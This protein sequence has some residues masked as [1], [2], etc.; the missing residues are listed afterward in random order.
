MEKKYCWVAECAMTTFTD[1]SKEEFTSIVDCFSDMHSAVLEKVKESTLYD[2][3]TEPCFEDY[4]AYDVKIYPRKIVFTFYDLEY[5]YTIKECRD[6]IIGTYNAHNPTL[7]EKI[8][9]AW[10]NEENDESFKIILLALLKRDMGEYECYFNTHVV[11]N[12]NWAYEHAH[13]I[14]QEICDDTDLETILSFVRYNVGG[15]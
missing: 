6:D 12:E 10:K 13:N 8:N 14:M 9:D 4:V 1:R 15:N 11:L 5:I 2:I 7:V 3:L